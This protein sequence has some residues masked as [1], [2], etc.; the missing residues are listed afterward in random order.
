M[1]GSNGFLRAASNLASKRSDNL[2]D[3]VI[4]RIEIE[5][6][7]PNSE[8]PAVKA[9]PARLPSEA[10]RQMKRLPGPAYCV[11]A[12][13]IRSGYRPSARSRKTANQTGDASAVNRPRS[14]KTKR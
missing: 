5:R 1:S 11:L 8:H 2:D 7:V 6:P 12:F 3:G 9:V 14:L 4:C 10:R 13:D